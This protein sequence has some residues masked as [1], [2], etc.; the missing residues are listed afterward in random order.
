MAVPLRFTPAPIDPRTELMRQ[1]E[2]A[3]REH[4]EALLSAWSLLQTAHDKGMLELVAG[5]ITGRDVIAT[6]L[7]KGM[8]ST[9]AVNIMR[10]GI[11]LARVM[12]ALDPETLEKLT[13][14]LPTALSVAPS[15]SKPPSLWR[16]F[17]RIASD[18][19]RRGLA[20]VTRLL[21]VLGA[22]T[23]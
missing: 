11:A 21:T 3:P 23:K 20:L 13:K 19:G 17:K 9:D 10:N 6:E 4:A 1:V 7:G 8:K 5:L 15:D 12:S 22:A 18:D 14:H 16:L 2:Q